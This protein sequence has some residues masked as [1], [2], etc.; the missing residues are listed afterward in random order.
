MDGLSPE[1]SE[2]I[3]DQGK[4]TMNFKV[5]RR[6]SEKHIGKDGKSSEKHSVHMHVHEFE[7][8]PPEA[9]SPAP[10][11]KK[12]M[13]SMDASKAVGDSFPPTE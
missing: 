4:A 12:L 8:H 1:E 3:P 6:T 10:K 13:E 9:E 5:H 2:A 11:K 7:P